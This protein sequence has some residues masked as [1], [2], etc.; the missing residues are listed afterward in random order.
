MTTAH[1]ASSNAIIADT[2]P[3]PAEPTGCLWVVPDPSRR[4]TA[5]TDCDA[6]MT[7]YRRG[8]I[9]LGRLVHVEC[10]LLVVE[11]FP[12]FQVAVGRELMHVSETDLAALWVPGE[13]LAFAVLQTGVVDE[14]WSLARTDVDPATA[15]PAPPLRRGGAPWLAMAAPTTV[16]TGRTPPSRS[17]RRPAQ[18]GPPARTPPPTHQDVHADLTAARAQ[19]A[20]LK[21]TQRHGT[22]ALDILAGDKRRYAR[23]DRQF[24]FE[25]ELAFARRT[26]AD[27][28]EQLS[29][30]P[31][32]IGPDFL[33]TLY[34]SGINRQKVVNVVL[35][36]L[37]GRADRLHSRHPLRT[38]SGPGCP[39]RSDGLGGKCFRIALQHGSPSA[40]RLHYWHTDDGTI[41][42]SSVRLHDDMRP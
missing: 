32:R 23:R 31:W 20:A 37:L 1:A 17:R 21:A 18:V 4:R 10:D 34:S 7:T 13:I 22:D 35:D 24:Q 36:V 14:D 26:T 11:L 27:E 12:G 8:S 33:D 29:M 3:P 30:L 19:I 42:L 41:E 16:R 38:G 2:P 28:K 9:V 5:A 25:V 39:A 40:R 6:A 15:V